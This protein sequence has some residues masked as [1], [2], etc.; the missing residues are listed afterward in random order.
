MPDSHSK[1]SASS[2]DRWLTCAGSMVLTAGA[3]NSSSKYAAWGTCAHD[4]AAKYLSEGDAPSAYVGRIFQV[5]GFD[6][7]VDNDMVECVEHYADTVRQYVGDDGA[8]LVEQRVCYADYLGIEQDLAWG[9]ADAII[10]RGDEITVVDL[11]TGMGVEVSA[12]K[13]SQMSLYALGALAACQ[14][15]VGDFARVR[16]VISQPRVKKAPSE[17]DCSVADLEDWAKTYAAPAA[18][19]CR[20]AQNAF[21]QVY[22]WD[23]RFLNPSEKGCRWCAANATCSKLRN[24]IAA[25]VFEVVPASP[26]EFADLALPFKKYDGNEGE[27]LAACMSK[28]D[29]ISD[30]CKAIQAETER[31]LFAGDNVPGYKLVQGKRGARQWSNVDDAEKTLKS[32]RLKIEEM[33]D[34]KL[35]S[36]TSAEKLAKAETIGKRQWPKLQGLIVQSEGKPHV[37]P[38]TDPRPA[39][40]VK[41]VV[42]DFDD[43]SIA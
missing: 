12:E 13:N 14:G 23:E 2:S 17:W 16:M 6:I 35:I 15:L 9:T 27:W 21:G 11:K 5:D 26:D 24:E 28:V 38:A 39:I 37:A 29:L 10:A 41:P 3:D 36:P 22:D 42:E 33:Y 18:L 19:A 30:W 34:F 25:T 32:F 43:E 31:R 8:L 40:E 1:F 7:E 4:L 20:T